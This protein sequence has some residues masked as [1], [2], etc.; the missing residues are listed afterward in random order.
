MT[1]FE[2]VSSADALAAKW[3]DGQ[4]RKDGVTPYITHPRRV[5]NMVSVATG[6]NPV[7]FAV[8]LLHDVLE[9][10]AI[11]AADLLALGIP[12]IY[13]VWWLTSPDKD[14]SRL[15]D[16]DRDARKWMQRRKIAA[17]PTWCAEIK[18]ADRLDNLRDMGGAFDEDFKTLYHKESK[19]LLGYILDRH[20]TLLGT[21]AA[22]EIARLCS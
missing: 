7:S 3:H 1:D 14:G 15:I 20:P 12:I 22:T 8:A 13:G 5:A 21:A 2:L 17:A 18:L 4:F 11:P 16:M 6:G 19:E 10:T 9:D